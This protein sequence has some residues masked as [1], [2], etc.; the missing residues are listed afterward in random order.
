MA[1]SNADAKPIAEPI[2]GALWKA[3]LLDV[4]TI[5]TELNKLWAKF[6][7]QTP[8]LREHE[9]SSE[10]SSHAVAIQTR[11]STFNLIAVGRSAPD[12]LRIDTTIRQLSELYPSRTTI[13]V[14]DPEH[15]TNG[16]PGLEVAV[17]LLEQ[18][19]D[20]GRPAMR[21]ESVT[22]RVNAAREQYLASI[23]SP[24][25]VIDLPD[26]LWWASDQ[27]EGSALFDDLLS[28]C[29]RLIVDSARFGDGADELRYLSKLV[30]RGHEFP[31]LSDFAWS[32]LGPWRQLMSQFFDPPAARPILGSLDMVTIWYSA[33][34]GAE[35]S[36]VTSAVLLA[37][38]LSSRLNWL[39]PGELLPARDDAGGWRITM[40]TG[41][42]SNRR[43]LIL[44]L[45]PG[46]NRA[47]GPGIHRVKLQ[48]DGGE[49]GS[50]EVWRLDSE[51]LASNSE[52]TGSAR[53]GRVIHAPIP[54][55]SKLLAYE[56]RRYVRDTA[57]E[58]AL[59]DAARLAPISFED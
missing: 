26:F 25:L 56:L 43:E 4:N 36:G 15:P 14:S 37:G 39:A 18:L 2:P 6:G 52:F 16:D 32:R 50:F 55:E 3:H 29:D 28:V 42:P 5:S 34:D 31:K 12:A 24:L 51:E 17:A 53:V 45:R 21:F 41:E 57:Y 40:R 11:A 44:A 7:T 58:A 23:A 38:W 22:V 8:Q 49:S 19:A 35:T 1:R 30:A 33:K 20:K 9:E 10:S 47:L 13:L 27:V 48:A 59:A 54:P 46:S